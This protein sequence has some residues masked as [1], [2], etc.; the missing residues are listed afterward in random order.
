VKPDYLPA[1]QEG[2]EPHHAAD[3]I[4][5]SDGKTYHAYERLNECG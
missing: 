3:G 2:Q 5:H 4:P 1:Q